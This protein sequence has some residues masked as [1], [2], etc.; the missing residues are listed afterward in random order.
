MIK[1][2]YVKL[3]KE[4]NKAYWDNINLTAQRSLSMGNFNFLIKFIGKDY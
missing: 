2:K 3:F 4:Q 1:D